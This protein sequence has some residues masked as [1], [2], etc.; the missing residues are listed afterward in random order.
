MGDMADALTDDMMTPC[1]GCGELSCDC[2][3]F[4]DVNYDIKRSFHDNERRLALMEDSAD[5]KAWV[6]AGMDERMEPQ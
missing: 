3:C 6:W 1:D 5:E 4:S 2:E